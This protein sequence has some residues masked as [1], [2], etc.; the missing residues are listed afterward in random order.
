[1]LDDYSPTRGDVLD[2]NTKSDAHNNTLMK[3]SLA[4][5][6]TQ[7]QLPAQIAHTEL[8]TR[9]RSRVARHIHRSV[10]VT[11]SNCSRGIA[12]P[13]GYTIQKAPRIRYSNVL[14][15]PDWLISQE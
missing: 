11:T 1:M 5:R 8:A 3:N 14:D 13:R 9:R 15:S 12:R 2:P 4:G 7:F 6:L 10:C